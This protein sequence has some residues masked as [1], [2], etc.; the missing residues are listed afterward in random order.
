MADAV[1]RRGGVDRDSSDLA[2]IGPE[3]VQ[4]AATDH[5]SV[6]FGHP[7]FL[8]SLIQRHQVL[9]QQDLSRVGVDEL[10]DRGDVRCSRAPDRQPVIP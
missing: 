5:F 10:L 4:G 7:E 3:H 1:A 6:E 9:F 8:D 2:E